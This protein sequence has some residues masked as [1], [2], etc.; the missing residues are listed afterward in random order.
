MKKQDFVFVIGVAVLL[1]PFFAFEPVLRWY[2]SFNAAHR[3]AMSFL[4]F[5][6]LSTLGEMIGLRISAGVYCRKGFGIL[7]RMLVWGILGMGINM[8]MIIFSNGTPVFL[9]YLG[10]S[11]APAVFHASGLSWFKVL[12]A[13]AVSVSMNTIFAPV[14]MTLHKITD[15]HILATGGTLAGFFT[16]I[17][18]RKIMTGLNW[19][20]LWGFVFKKTIP[21][22][23]FPAHTLTF[24][25][26]GNMRV[27]C[28]ALLGVV[29]GILLAV[30]A[31][32]GE[33]PAKS[34]S[35]LKPVR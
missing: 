4:K 13:F 7:P 12:V 22:F 28:A 5:A 9:Q 34:R 20:V 21:F 16:P 27:L 35:S 31:R 3:M 14:F 15:T 17:P 24:L 1:L 19:G 30:A 23:W 26:P 6:F 25:L 33:I 8:A 2:H 10:M 11:E 32:K 18:M 29:L